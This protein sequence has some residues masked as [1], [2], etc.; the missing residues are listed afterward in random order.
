MS[1]ARGDVRGVLQIVTDCH[2]HMGERAVNLD[3]ARV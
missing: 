1:A 3:D 2:I